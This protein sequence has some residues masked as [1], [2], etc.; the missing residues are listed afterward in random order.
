[1]KEEQKLLCRAATQHAH[2]SDTAAL[3]R[4]LA[5]SGWATLLTLAESMAPQPSASGGGAN[6][7]SG[8][9]ERLGAM[10]I[11][12]PSHTPAPGDDGGGSGEKVCPHCTFV[13]TGPGADC[14]I[15]GLPLSG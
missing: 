7:G 6:G 5:S 13:N 8:Y 10:G 15:C 14:D 1:M 4:L 2:S 11:Q 3:D 9:T 12:S